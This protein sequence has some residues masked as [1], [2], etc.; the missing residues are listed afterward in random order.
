MFD[1]V[2]VMM[3]LVRIIIVMMIMVMMMK[4]M[5]MI[6]YIGAEMASGAFLEQLQSFIP[7]RMG[8][9]GTGKVQNNLHHHHHHHQYLQLHLRHY[10]NHTHCLC[11]NISFIS[12]LTLTSLLR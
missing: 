8:E 2:M 7:G 1:L 12:S 6:V 10:L 4:V 5:A 11:S 3:M 9:M